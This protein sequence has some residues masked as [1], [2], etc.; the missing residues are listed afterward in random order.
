VERILSAEMGVA[1][2]EYEAAIERAGK[3]V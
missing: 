3:S 2:P 1:W